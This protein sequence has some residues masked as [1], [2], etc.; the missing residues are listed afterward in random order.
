LISPTV[1]PASVSMKQS[2]SPMDSTIRVYSAASGDFETKSNS[3][4]SG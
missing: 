4:Y 2:D 3:Q 1:L